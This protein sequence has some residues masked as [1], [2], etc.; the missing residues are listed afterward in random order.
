MN[1][2]M[3]VC[4]PHRLQLNIHQYFCTHTQ[5]TYVCIYIYTHTYRHIFVRTHFIHTR[6]HTRPPISHFNGVGR[7]RRPSMLCHI[8]A[9]VC[10]HFIAC[11]RLG[12]CHEQRSRQRR[13]RVA[14]SSLLRLGQRQ[15]S[16]GETGCWFEIQR[17][18]ALTT[19]FV[20]NVVPGLFWRDAARRCKCGNRERE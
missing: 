7:R 11:E 3:Y 5:H 13:L 15:P 18:L 20:V 4:M 2:C 10:Q 8:V 12:T 9:M 1:V 16:D 19:R 14:I 6:T 17:L